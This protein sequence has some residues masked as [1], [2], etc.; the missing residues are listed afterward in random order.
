MKPQKSQQPSE[1]KQCHGCVKNDFKQTNKN[2]DWFKQ[3]DKQL[4]LSMLVG[5]L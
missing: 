5:V 4:P 3:Q 2:V 1:C